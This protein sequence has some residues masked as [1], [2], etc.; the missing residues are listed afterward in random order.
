MS[1]EDG[2]ASLTSAML[3]GDATTFELELEEVLK[4]TMSYFDFGQSR[5]KLTT[6]EPKPIEAVYQAFIVGLLLRLQ[7]HYRIRSNRESAYGR[8]DVM[9]DP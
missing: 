6:R 7:D 5:P 1:T 9:L 3:R 4:N 8:A 2:L